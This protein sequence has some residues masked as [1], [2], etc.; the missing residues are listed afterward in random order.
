[1]RQLEV[2]ISPLVGKMRLMLCQC[3]PG[4]LVVIG[5]FDFARQVTT[6]LPRFAQVLLVELWILVA[7][8]LVIHEKI[9][10]SE[11]E[12][13]ALT[14][15]GFGNDDLLKDTEHEPQPTHLISLDRQGFNLSAYRAM[16]HKLV[17]GPANGDGIG[18]HLI[19]RLRKGERGILPGFLK[20]GATLR[21]L[22]EKR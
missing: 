7:N 5:A 20:P 21:Q 10:Q 6:Q 12:T 3:A 8:V 2:V 15:A 9:L 22:I 1:M 16:F 11:V 4:T 19:A 14:R 18:R 13:A 17:L